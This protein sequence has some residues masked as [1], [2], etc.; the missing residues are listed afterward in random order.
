MRVIGSATTPDDRAPL[1]ESKLVGDAS[2]HV[3][4]DET[5]EAIEILVNLRN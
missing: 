5:I 1:G 3:A 4:H 2:V